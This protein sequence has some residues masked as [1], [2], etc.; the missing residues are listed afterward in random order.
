M[1]DAFDRRAFFRASLDKLRRGLADAVEH[2]LP[3][4][5]SRFAEAFPSAP[6]RPVGPKPRMVVRPPG[7][8]AEPAFLDTCERCRACV[9]ACPEF[10]IIPSQ[11]GM[12]AELGTPYLLPEQAPCTFCHECV[13]AC[14]TGALQPFDKAT[15]S[16]GTAVI[17]PSHCIRS[18]GEDCTRCVEV[19]PRPGLAI[20]IEPSPIDPG[21]DAPRYL[22]E[23]L[24]SPEH[25]TG[26][27]YCGLACPAPA[28]AITIFPHA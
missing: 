9:D 11:P 23:P 14:P 15:V 2:T 10:C 19:C 17:E 26:C 22:S 25:C 6:P 7:A 1:S 4:A 3:A 8:L 20:R 16:I 28:R 12:A 5:A 21:S 24:V 13:D 18:H 27:G